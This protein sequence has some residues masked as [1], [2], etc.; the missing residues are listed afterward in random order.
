MFY[1]NQKFSENDVVVDANVTESGNNTVVGVVV[2]KPGT[3]TPVQDDVVEDALHQTL[4]EDGQ[5][6]ISS[7]TLGVV[8]TP[9]VSETQQNNAASVRLTNINASQVGIVF[10]CTF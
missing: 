10:T 5:S 7:L 8:N 3:T 1:R 9:T 2:N 4:Q 6:D